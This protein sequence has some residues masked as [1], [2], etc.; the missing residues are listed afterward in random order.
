MAD[1]A[2]NLDQRTLKR[3][4]PG[5]RLVGA[6]RSA[7]D[8]RKLVIAALGLALLQL[9]WSIL[10][11]L[12]PDSAAITPEVFEAAGAAGITLSAGPWSWGQLAAFHWRLSEPVARDRI[13][14]PCA[15]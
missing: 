2:L 7:F 13:P 8:L 1:E 5:L 4:F 12:S 11:R 3:L 14:T 15:P 6:I 10:D 9:G